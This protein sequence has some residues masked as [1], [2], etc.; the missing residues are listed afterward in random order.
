L[1][2]EGGE[3]GFRFPYLYEWYEM[4]FYIYAV[5]GGPALVFCL[6]T[7][8][9]F[10]RGLVNTLNTRTDEVPENKLAFLQNLILGELVKLYDHSIWSLRHAVRNLEKVLRTRTLQI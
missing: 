10:R 5:P 2:T 6:D 8:I 3:A 9:V 1:K 7:P 4:G